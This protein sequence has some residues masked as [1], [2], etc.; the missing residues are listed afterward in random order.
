[1]QST[2]LLNKHH[3]DLLSQGDRQIRLNARR[4]REEEEERQKKLV[5]IE[6]GKYQQEVRR[7]AIQEARTKQYHQ[8]DRI[9]AFHVS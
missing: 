5:D 3:I 8:T 6:E 9:K 7:K 1:M 4:K 2:A